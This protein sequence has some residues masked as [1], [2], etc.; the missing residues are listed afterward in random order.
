MDLTPGAELPPFVRTTGFEHWNRYAAVNDEFVPMHMDDEAGREAGFPTAI[1]MGNLIWAYFHRVLRDWLGE[2]GRIETISARYSLPNLRNS[3]LT[4]RAKVAEASEA[5]G[6]ARVV[7][8]LT[9]DDDADRR[10]VTG[11]ATVVLKR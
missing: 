1:G 7:F 2:A 3:T 6:E 11:Q 5:A 9:A 8:D 4:I 10:L